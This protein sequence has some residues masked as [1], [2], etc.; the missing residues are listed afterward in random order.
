MFLDPRFPVLDLKVARA[1]ANG[2]FAPLSDLRFDKG[3]IRITLSNIR[4]YECWARWC[5]EI[6][7]VVNEEPSSPRRGLRAV[8]VER[9]L[10]TLADRPDH[11]DRA[12]KL[13]AG[14]EGWTFDCTSR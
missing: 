4:A 1:F 5:R 7:G 2:R 14:P 3:G 6:A 11:R 13:L 9:A 10:F 12:R 8:D